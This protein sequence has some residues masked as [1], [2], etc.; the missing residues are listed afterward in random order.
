M[1]LALVLCLLAGQASGAEL[2]SGQAVYVP[3]YSQIYHG[4]RTRPI[5]LTITLSVRNIDPKRSV[6]LT[7]VDFYDTAGK[8]VRRYLDTPVQMAPLMTREFIV[9]QTDTA[10]GSGANFI[11]LWSA[12]PPANPLFVEAVM[13]GTTGQQGISFSSHGIALAVE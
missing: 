4:I 3:C 7:A 1:V 6:T 11:V 2:I 10:G 9:G 13:I 5:D 12:D 8:L